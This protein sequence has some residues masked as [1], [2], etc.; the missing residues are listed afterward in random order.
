MAS[1]KT[2]ILIIEHN[3]A[4]I[5]AIQHALKIG[6][7]NCI[8]ET[9]QSEKN[10]EKAVLNFKPD[11][12]L[13][14]YTSPTFDG[15]AVFA[16]KEKLVPQTPFIFVSGSI[17]EENAVALIKNGATDFVLKER[18]ETLTDKIN[19]ALEEVATINLKAEHK[20][21]EEKRAEE[22]SENESKYFSL[23]ESSMD[24][25]LQTVK[26]GRILGAN[27]AACE[28]F[29]M[30][31][32]EMCNSGSFD[33]IDSA[34]PRLQPLLKERNRTGRAKG[35]LIF[36]RKD[37]SKFPGEITSVVFTDAYGQEK[38]SITIRDITERKQA[39]Q[40]LKA[41][42]SFSKGI[43]DSLTSHIA[44]INSKG[45]IL[46]V[47]KSWNTFAQNNGGNSTEKYGE[48]TNYFDA[49]NSQNNSTEDLASKALKG[50]KD[51]LNGIINEFYLEYPCH[52]PVTERW[53]KMRVNI[54]GSSETM[55]LIEHHDISERKM[56]EQK[57]SLTTDDLQQAL[58][59]LNKILDSSL[60]VICSFDEE[61]RFVSVNAA[62]EYLW[63]YKPE[64]L[65][66]KKYI[67]LVFHE[68]IEKTNATDVSIRGGMPVTIFENRYVHK[69]GHIVPV[70]WSS[71]WDKKNKLFYSTVKD[72]SE[73]KNLEKEFE[74]ERQWFQ[75]LYSQA[76]SCM[77]ILKGSNHVYELANDLYL[78]LIDKKKDII[79]KTVKE[80]LP[81]LE[82]Q[83]IF[84]FLDTVY[85]TGETFSA[86]EMLVKFDY[87]G[88]GK[89]VDTYLNFIYQAHR[90]ID[91]TIDG[92]F[93][94]ANNVTEQVLSRKKIE[95][96]M[97]RYSSLIEQASDAICIMDASMIIIDVN[98]YACKKLGYSRTEIFQLS[99]EDFF[100]E[101]DLKANPLKMDALKE[102]KTV[103]GE[104]RIKRKDN[105]LIDVEISA[106]M[107]KDGSTLLFVRDITENKKAQLALMESEKKYRQIVETAQEGIW[108]INDN[109][110]TTFVNEKMCQILEYT[111]N[112]MMG[113]EIFAFMDEE[114][115]RIATKL[116]KNK[117]KGKSDKRHF[118]YISKSGKEIWANITANP[119][120]DE[121]GVYKGSLAMVTDITEIKKV[122]KTL[123]RNE[124]KYRYLFENNPVPMWVIDLITFK[125]LDVNNMA[126]LQYGYSREEFLS[127][128]ALDIRPD[129]DKDHFTKSSDPSEINATNFNRGIWN[130]K[131]KNGTIIEVEIIAH[132][133]IYEGVP[134]RFILSND[135]TDRRKAEQNLEIRNK[136]IRDYKFAMDESNIVGITDHNGVIIFANDNFCK[137]SQYSREEL[138]GKDHRILNSGYHSKAY[139]Q[140]KWETIA[141]GKTWKG[142][143][144]N[145]A[146]D[147]T[148]YWVD[149]TIIP[150]LDEEGKPYQYFATRFDITERKKADLNLEK[151]NK[152]LVKTNAEL[153]RFV[154]SVSH[155]LRS[156]LTSILGLLS[157]IE[158]ESQE[159]DT[160]EHAE[161]IHK[162]IDRLDEFIKNILSYSRNNRTGLE[163]EQI[164]LQETALDIV[165]SL[166]SM[167]EAIGIDYE[168]DI[169]EQHPFFTD[170]L[171]F[172]NILENLISNAIK[173][174]KKDISGRYIK[175]TGQSDTEK[176]Q[177][178]IADNGIGI[179]PA[180]H[181][182]IFDMF[183]RLSGK[184][185][186]SGIGLYIVKDT[187]EILQGSIEIQSEKGIGTTF[188]ITLKNLKP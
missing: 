92:I 71:R 114:G 7:V 170:R 123:K 19:R 66:G 134:A 89:L 84:E 30:T 149:T 110:K 91:G 80:V 34:D 175:I 106:K 186:G 174:H 137:I 29:K 55:V 72:A 178:S 164:S 26:D 173:H 165:D 61:G 146:K 5:M 101:E 151:Q 159:P 32:E 52:S 124:K 3:P 129:K 133:I 23:I 122:Q 184:K 58:S 48:G 57:L 181:Q 139:I 99:V 40:A 127:M 85:K 87:H 107:L 140:N 143:I 75:D 144:K 152:E 135:I 97:L 70:L 62:S 162:S 49:C 4:D 102:G 157:F 141:S 112:E 9:V 16:I 18:L 38:T 86:N 115:Q 69:D 65:I 83:G 53:F 90:D 64:E 131:K 2:K 142:E 155:D 76:P 44:V 185:D 12:I 22:L 14:N 96:S 172:N 88:K 148:F 113:K 118:K 41:S 188:T 60:D 132:K 108:L 176:L 169:E 79:G 82:A 167:R 120:F 36:K 20:L 11:I 1:T 73:K 130:H 116:I 39:E 78:Q 24:G 54:F 17:G 81:E 67:D 37:G 138:I 117:K 31:R 51:V 128:T 179:A 25:I 33:I 126:I 109:H 105:T 158:G 160:L 171:R 104:R 136:E 45:T 94:F 15:V 161:M 180:Y 28:I 50:I 43:L 100:L 63:G 13:S 93:F 150:F 42:E 187:I 183:F 35:E 125:F 111:Q 182:K 74:T 56:A 59:D 95:E 156:P 147:G 177:F 145:K 10:F 21:S 27:T 153:D 6:Y 47:N 121:Q 119:L 77:G 8:T 163:V 98:P 68:D 103:R 168:I 46:K 154:Y 166:Q